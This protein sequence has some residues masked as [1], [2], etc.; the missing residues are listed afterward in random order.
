M[1]PAP[2]SVATA[3]VSA[4]KASLSG[5]AFG[6]GSQPWPWRGARL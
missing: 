5:G 1:V 6:R 2:A 3:A 4:K